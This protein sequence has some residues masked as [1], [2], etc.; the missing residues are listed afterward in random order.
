[1]S[2][3]RVPKTMA[4][5]LQEV[6]E[7]LKDEP[8]LW[9]RRGTEWVPTSWRQYAQRMR[10]F[11]LGL[12]SLGFSPKQALT[13][14]GGNRE[15]W[16]V[17][18]L[19]AMASGGFA[20]GVYATSS[21]E[22]M[23]YITRH[24]EASLALVENETFLDTL[25]SVR[26]DLPKL[27][28]II[29]MDAPATPREGILTFAEVLERGARANEADYYARLETVDPEHLAQL[30]YTSG[31]TGQPKGVMLSHR[32]VCWTAVHLCQSHPVDSKDVV[33]SYL[34]LAHIAEQLCS[35]Y[36]P[37]LKGVQVYFAPSFEKLGDDLQEVR[38]T[39]F[40]GVPRVWEKFKQRIEA[41]IAEQPV[42]AQR[43]LAW[44]QDVAGRFH[45]D[46]MS[47][48][49]STI[50]LQAQYAL[51]KRL[52]FAPLKAKLG[53]DRANILITS[54]APIAVDVLAFFASLDLP[55]AELYGQSEA[56]GP[57]SVS[58]QMAM[59]FGKVGR[60]MSGV[61]VRIAHDGEIL[62][63][64]DNVCQGYFKDPKATKELLKNGWLH[65]GDIGQLD[66]DGLLAIT[67]RKKELIV[68][69]GGKK[70]APSY[71]EGLLK[72][73]EPVSHAVVVGEARSH[74]VALLTLDA[75]AVKDF[76][77]KRHFPAALPELAT[78][79]GFKTYLKE[80]IDR[81]VNSRVAKYETIK[82]FEVL[83]NEFTIEG[84]ELTSTLKVRRAAVAQKYS[85]VLKSLYQ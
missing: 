3:L 78:H 31:T 71:L 72:S 1:M 61:E 48:R 37:I 79:E 5:Q 28:H 26:A 85:S 10:D 25:L 38:P 35:V 27:K 41:S 32:N 75:D 6:A 49:Q 42:S 60:P 67:G 29:V 66:D 9:T 16:L 58:T 44:A 18:A 13:V 70:T 84:G 56:T 80:A 19:G 76:A 62:V 68:T 12:Q 45:D 53:F 39:I 46:A 73:I 74:L 34:P 59:Q 83:P 43:L 33:L 81:E 52:V 7:R 55:V 17:A 51:A 15:E 63:K 65:S 11:A 69:S 30:I 50:T 4:H 24:C 21:A 54:A 8:A 2:S 36:V 14:T 23:A 82:R 64:G 20:V 77:S 40:V 22:Q 47:H 57:T